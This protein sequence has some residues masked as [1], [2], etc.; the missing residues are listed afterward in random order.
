MITKIIYNN[1]KKIPGLSMDFQTSF[2]SEDAVEDIFKSYKEIFFNSIKSK[3]YP[4]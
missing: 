1:P 2:G 4:R 3:I